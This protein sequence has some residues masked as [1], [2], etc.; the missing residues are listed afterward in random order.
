M[1]K[2][3][4]EVVQFAWAR[5]CG[6][7]RK[8]SG[9]PAI[10]HYFGVLRIISTEWKISDRFTW[11]LAMCHD[12]KED[13]NV[14]HDELVELIGSHGA[15]GVEELTFVPFHHGPST[16][17]QQK[18]EYIK[19]FANKSI[20]SVVV[21]FADRCDNTLDFIIS[22]PDYAYKY[23]SKAEPLFDVLTTRESE[24]KERYSMEALANIKYARTQIYQR[25]L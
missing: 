9:L 24:I 15:N 13:C 5:S 8:V 25:V 3:F 23:W 18:R 11:D 19:S 22:Q 20:E 16:V 21:K 6:Q 10:S 4:D 7:Q 1:Q 17:P 14:T 12:L 2:S